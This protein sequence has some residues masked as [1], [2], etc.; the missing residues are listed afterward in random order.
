VPT[1]ARSSSHFIFIVSAYYLLL[2]GNTGKRVYKKND[3]SSNLAALGNIPLFKL[4]KQK[5]VRKCRK[6]WKNSLSFPLF[7]V[8]LFFFAISCSFCIFVPLLTALFQLILFLNKKILTANM[9]FAPGHQ[10]QRDIVLLFIHYHP[11]FF[12]LI[13]HAHITN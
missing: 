9:H 6:T 5:R 1:R 11:L 8:S 12:F 7:F 10:R 3:V 13:R 2:S 4:L